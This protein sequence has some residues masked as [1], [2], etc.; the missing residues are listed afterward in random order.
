MSSSGL[1]P[2]D[3][4]IGTEKG[5]KIQRML[6]AGIAVDPRAVGERSP[7]LATE[8]GKSGPH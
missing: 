4:G 8:P 5:P 1:D 7:L 6:R 2:L 3:L